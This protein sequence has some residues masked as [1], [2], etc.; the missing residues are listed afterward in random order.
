MNAVVLLLVS[1]CVVLL[2]AEETDQYDSKFDNI[3]L[4]EIFRSDRLIKNY[5]Q[6][7][8]EKGNCTPQGTAIKKNLPDALKTECSKCTE[9]Q[10]ENA[11]K[12]LNFLF[13]EKPD[14]YKE[15]E[16]KY[17]PEQI[18]RKKKEKLGKF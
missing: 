11:K 1:I 13:D 4:E 5:H 18:Y 9:K 17:D 6:C 12:T 15:L 2:T 10:K 8:M 3:D 14:L 7:F 16:A